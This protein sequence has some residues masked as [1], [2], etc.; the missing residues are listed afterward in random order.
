MSVA[1]AFSDVTAHPLLD[2]QRD[3]PDGR[4]GGART[5][6]QGIWLLQF[7]SAP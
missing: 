6:D 3:K 2:E 7:P 5:R 1:P 4:A